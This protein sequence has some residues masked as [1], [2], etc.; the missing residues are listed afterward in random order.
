MV[1]NRH[2]E[3]ILEKW[4]VKDFRKPLLI[5]GARQVGKTTLVNNFAKKYKHKILL[6]LERPSDLAYF[7]N[8]NDVRRL[9]D[10]LFLV[11]NIP[12][13][14]IANTLLFIDE[15]QE[16]PEAIGLLRYFYEDLPQL[17]VIAAGS[18][19]EHVMQ[20]VKSYPVGRVEYLYL[21][22]LNFTEFLDAKNQEEALEQLN[23]I[24]VNDFAHPVLL[25]LFHQ[26]AIIGGMPEVISTWLTTQS[27]ADLP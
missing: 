5:R 9:T 23:V 15:I 21:H 1:F 12:G 6:N 4:K 11:N 27:L 3:K 25:D 7:K 16:S 24:P 17:N 19:L 14:E 20:K 26:Y 22:P 10:A 13:R 2:I 18:L 8:F